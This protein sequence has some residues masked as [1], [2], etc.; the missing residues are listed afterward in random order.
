MNDKIARLKKGNKIEVYDKNLVSY[1]Q[2]QVGT[3]LFARQC[4][5]HFE[6]WIPTIQQMGKAFKKWCDENKYESKEYKKL[7]KYI[8]EVKI[9]WL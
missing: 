1:L 9:I 7:L 4:E 5:S 2:E 3:L 8:E 6:V